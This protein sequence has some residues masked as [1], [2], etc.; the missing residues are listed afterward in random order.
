VQ[1]NYCDLCSSPLKENNYFMLYVS[2]PKKT[3]YDEMTSYVEYLKKVERGVKEICPN[4]KH[5]FDKMFELKLQRLSELTNELNLI[6]KLPSK[7]N[8]KERGN[9]KEKK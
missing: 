2:E 8:L 4:C 9:D 3:N 7:K 1:V 5:I 6:Y